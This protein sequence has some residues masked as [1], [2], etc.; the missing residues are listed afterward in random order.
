[1]EISFHHKLIFFYFYAKLSHYLIKCQYLLHKILCWPAALK[2]A[3]FYDIITYMTA[4]LHIHSNLSDGTD[5]PEKLVELALTAKLKSISITDHDVIDGFGRAL[6]AAQGKELEV[7]PGVEFTTENQ[8]NEVHI[9]GYYF[10]VQNSLLHDQVKKMQKGRADRVYLI[11]DRLKALGFEIKPERVFE[12]A[13]HKSPGRPHIAKALLEAG[14]TSTFK[15]AFDR[16]LAFNGP[17]YISHYKLFPNEAVKLIKAAGG[18]PVFAHPGL[19]KSDEIIP[20]LIADG[21]AGIEVYYPSH[22]PD[23]VANYE[24]MANKYNLIMTGGS[25]YH[26][27]GTGRTDAMLG[28]FTIPDELVDNLRKL[29]G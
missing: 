4:D 13:G 7:L 24:L 26:G 3:Y 2:P 16:F 29:K 6:L 9:L 25:D 20:D 28:N 8:A 17:A 14:I 11:I 18:I 21:L 19:S 12:I 1:M 27:K 10:D 22:R 15:E 5:S 23:Q